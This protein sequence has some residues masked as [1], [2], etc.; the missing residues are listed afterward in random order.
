MRDLIQLY[1]DALAYF[2]VGFGDPSLGRVR[3]KNS[4]NNNCEASKDGASHDCSELQQAPARHVMEKHRAQ[5]FVTI[6]FMGMLGW[7]VNFMNA[8]W[9]GKKDVD[10]I[11]FLWGFCFF[12]VCVAAALYLMRRYS[13]VNVAS[14]IWVTGLIQTSHY[15]HSLK[16]LSLEL[17][18]VLFSLGVP[19][20]MGLFCTST[21]VLGISMVSLCA[22]QQY[23]I[24]HSLIMGMVTE[25]GREDM[26]E[27]IE[28][29]AFFMNIFSCVLFLV[30]WYNLHLQDDCVKR[31]QTTCKQAQESKEV[32]ISCISHELRNPLQS[33]IGCLQLL[34]NQTVL[35][36]KLLELAFLSSQFLLQIINQVLDVTKVNAASLSLEYVQLDL[37]ELIEQLINMSKSSSPKRNAIETLVSYETAPRYIIGDK[38]RLTQVLSNLLSNAFKFTER[39]SVKLKASFLNNHPIGHGRRGC[40][41]SQHGDHETCKHHVPGVLTVTISDTGVGIADIHKQRLFKPFVQVDTSVTRKYGGTGLG[42]YLCQKLVHLMSGQINVTSEPGVGTTFTVSLPLCSIHE[43]SVV[44]GQIVPGSPPILTLRQTS[45]L[46]SALSLS[47]PAAVSSSLTSSDSSVCRNEP[48]PDPSDRDIRIPVM[49]RSMSAGSALMAKEEDTALESLEYQ[50]TYQYGSDFLDRS[51]NISSNRVLSP[52]SSNQKPV[53]TVSSVTSATAGANST[54]ASACVSSFSSLNV[55]LVEDSHVNR[56]IIQKMLK[57]LLDIQKVKVCEDGVQATRVLELAAATG[58]NG[59]SKCPFDIVITDIQMPNM[60]GISLT[61]WI[62]NFEKRMG[63]KRTG[64]IALTGNSTLSDKQECE[65]AGLDSFLVKP[66][67]AK[68]LKREVELILN[69]R[70]FNS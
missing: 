68:Q 3:N 35:D 61:R 13:A 7:P 29:F 33:I 32:F 66:I 48:S 21:P 46:T 14:L 51:N 6:C 4:N 16:N 38:V 34:R 41:K 56:L 42:L 1:R 20:G 19:V 52:S 57:S 49:Q 24:R 37:H 39:G 18:V 63:W 45:N 54:S 31:M 60:D 58:G 53:D 59:P 67:D 11:D 15:A 69:S 5:V 43:S 22:I 36:T 70:D 40:D 25:W 55:L 9:K 26:V 10:A 44:S 23:W 8:M 62:R 50:V 30:S 17:P 64:I 47:L 12:E 2:T 28:A 65:A 27:M